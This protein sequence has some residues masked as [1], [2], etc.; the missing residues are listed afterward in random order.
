MNSVKKEIP[1]MPSIDWGKPFWACNSLMTTVAFSSFGTV[2]LCC[3]QNRDWYN[4]YAIKY[5]RDTIV[6]DKFVSAVEQCRGKMMSNINSEIECVCTG[7]SELRFRTWKRPT[8]PFRLVIVGSRCACNINCRYCSLQQFGEFREQGIGEVDPG[9][10]L[11]TLFQNRYLAPGGQV[12]LST[13]EPVIQPFFSDA[14]RNVRQYSSDLGLVLYTNATVYSP[15][16]EPLLAENRAILVV[17]VDAGTRETFLKIKRRDLF[18][19]VVANMERY[20]SFMPPKIKPKYLC[21]PENINSRDRDGFMNL[22]EKW[23]T[24]LF[25]LTYDSKYRDGLPPKFIDFMGE[26]K[27][28][29]GRRGLSVQESY[30]YIG[31]DRHADICDRVEESYRSRLPEYSY[32]F[33]A[34]A[35]TPPTEMGRLERLERA[36]DDG[37]YV[38]GWAY[39]RERT[40]N[41]EEVV[42]AWRGKP[43]FAGICRFMRQDVSPDAKTVF[44]F[45][46]TSKAQA[47]AVLAD[48]ETVQAYARFGEDEWI[49][50]EGPFRRKRIERE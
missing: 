8:H 42:V 26:F 43:I 9:P 29:A 47:S 25:I 44:S 45:H 36:G 12:Y 33:E 18:D 5:S 27:Y 39:D 30:R 2:R 38:R 35:E 49:R 32:V 17:S 22:L 23:G 37:L 21:V 6:D 48:S 15:L 3:A 4:L 31:E 40:R 41:A 19:Q 16:V 11:Q 34:A 50:L 46:S 20:A 14:V 13:G 24:H 1:T 7:C 28:L 10:I